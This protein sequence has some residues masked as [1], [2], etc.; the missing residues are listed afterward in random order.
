MLIAPYCSN[1]YIYVIN[2]SINQS[3]SIK[4]NL[5]VR[6]SYHL[7]IHKRQF[8]RNAYVQALYH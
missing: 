7:L 4:I 5:T 3:V 1:D 2:Q 6:F 8:N